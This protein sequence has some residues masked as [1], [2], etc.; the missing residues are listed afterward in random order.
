MSSFFE[1]ILNIAILVVFFDLLVFTYS[2]IRKRQDIA[3]VVWGI[4]F[5]LIGFLALI[6]T[7]NYSSLIIITFLLICT[8]G[9]RLFFH[10]GYRHLNK[11][12]DKR[13]LELSKNWGKWFHLRSL[14][15]NFLFQGL[16]ALIVSIPVIVIIFFNPEVNYY[17]LFIGLFIWAFGFI[18][19]A[20]AD[21]ELKIFIKTKREPSEVMS[22]G[23]WKYSRHPNYFGE[24]LLWWG[25]FILSLHHLEYWYVS[26]IGPLAIT[27]LILFVSGIPLNEKRFGGNKNYELYKKRVSPFLPRPPKS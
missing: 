12:E 11:T 20:I 9:L 6:L 18:F 16:L 27:L 7:N 15:Q 10:I 25:I 4:K 2:V 26:I 21:Y 22:T 13:Y 5:I 17:L 24:V 14:V 1:L 3:D 8:W 23:L 19:E